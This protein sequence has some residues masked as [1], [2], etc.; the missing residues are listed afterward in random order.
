MS[1][2]L[3]LG[4]AVCVPQGDVR[5]SD[6]IRAAH[7]GQKLEREVEAA[8]AELVSPRKHR[9]RGIVAPEFAVKL[10]A[11][12]IAVLD[13]VRAQTSFAE[14]DAL[15]PVA[16]L[17]FVHSLASKSVPKVKSKALEI[18]EFE[19]ICERIHR[20]LVKAVGSGRDVETAAARL[21][22]VLD[23]VRLPASTDDRD[24]A[25]RE[26]VAERFE[27]AGRVD[28]DELL[29][30]ARRLLTA[31]M[32]LVDDKHLKKLRKKKA[33]T[34]RNIEGVRGDVLFDRETSFGRLVVG[35]P[36]P[37]EYECS[38]VDVIVDIGG[39]DTYR[40]PAGGAGE[41]R[42]LAVTIDVEGN[43]RYQ[44]IN[45]GIGSAT[46]G[47]GLCLDMAG[48]DV[49][50]GGDRCL[51][52]GMAG[53]GMFLDLAGNDDYE[54][55]ALG[56]GAAVA[57][58]G[59]CLDLEGDD[60]FKAARESFDCAIGGGLGFCAD[61]AGDDRWTLGAETAKVHGRSFPVS[62][63]FG[64]GLG[65]VGELAGGVGVML[66]VAGDDHYI[67]QAFAGG[68]GVHGGCGVLCDTAGDDV[69]EFGAGSLAVS[70]GYGVGVVV[71][72]AGA[73]RFRATGFGFGSGVGGG[74]AWFGDVAG[75][76]QYD[77]TD[78]AAAI[79]RGGAVTGFVD[80]AGTD[81]YVKLE[82]ELR[83]PV[84][85]AMP[86]RAAIG[87]LIDGD[88]GMDA[89]TGLGFGPGEAVRMLE[90]EWPEGVSRRLFVDR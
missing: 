11:A 76:D 36:G 17:E 26:L 47:V 63:G 9:I 66:D 85:A 21:H 39:D 58:V 1:I 87:T 79:A 23:K 81:K 55:A 49:Y 67:A 82:G 57:G 90:V 73:D 4:L 34:P 12:G 83:W 72:S 52:F 38:Q 89:L 22:A 33:G 65:V 24:K 18:R 88:G 56:G 75:D 80:F 40:G 86:E 41:M 8:R 60:V 35:G 42:P 14:P 64:A 84:P 69:Y 3:T 51:G 62:F 61:V 54:I 27:R 37:N 53:V 59:V 30:L 44:A 20:D 25:T 32:R 74:S 70:I 46:F 16:A 28:R 5:L 43:D 29:V 10:R 7:E 19:K 78:A 2:T 15:A 6:S 31:S 68:V 45:G 50:R 48:D 71:E 77:V 13:Q